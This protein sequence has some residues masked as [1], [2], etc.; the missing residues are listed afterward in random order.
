MFLPREL[1]GFGSVDT[2]SLAI[3]DCDFG[4]KAAQS[5]ERFFLDQENR[6]RNHSGTPPLTLIGHRA[7]TLWC[8]SFLLGEQGYIEKTIRRTIITLESP[9]SSYRVHRCAMGFDGPLRVGFPP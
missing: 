9:V 8:M 7:K 4:R 2:K 3:C 5:F 6:I 1:W